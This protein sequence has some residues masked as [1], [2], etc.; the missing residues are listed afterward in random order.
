MKESTR[1][2]LTAVIFTALLS[3]C[4]KLPTG[5]FSIDPTE[6]TVYDE[7]TF[8]NSSTDADSYT[9]DFGDNNTST[10]VS[11][12]H[13]YLASGTY[14]VKLVASNE[15]GDTE[16]TQSLTVNDAHNYYTLDGTEF[17]FDSE[18]FWYTSPMGGD[19]YIR[20]LTTV[21]G[22]VNPDLLKLYPNK[23]LDEL[24]GTYTWDSDNPVGT[25][26][27][28]YTANYA[29]FS[30]DWTAIGKTGSGNLV[31]TE[32]VDG[33]YLFEAEAVLSVGDF[34]W[35]TGQFIEESTS[36]IKLE[37]RGAITSL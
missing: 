16:I 21:P 4:E 12:T 28:G 1:L 24:P 23:G 19:P 18:M 29:G 30:Y 2:V 26:D 9:W 6:I 25:Y 37:Y 17:V 11:P 3:G 5:N 14:T 20:L 34:D 8:T 7:V 32:L 27:A 31:I 10:E 13:I 33:I 22:Q 35:N 36:N 15:D